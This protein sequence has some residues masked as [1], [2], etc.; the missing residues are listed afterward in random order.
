VPPASTAAWRQSLLVNHELLRTASCAT[1]PSRAASSLE[2]CAARTVSRAWLASKKIV[3][4]RTYQGGVF[5]IGKED[6]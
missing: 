4:F 3:N 2:L 1:T 5:Y 6:R